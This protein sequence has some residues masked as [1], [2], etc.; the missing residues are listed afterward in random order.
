MDTDSPAP[1]GPADA[2]E[3]WT[4]RRRMAAAERARLLQARQDAE[5]ERAS[6]TISLF[7]QVAHAEG[8]TPQ[9]LRVQ[10]YSGGS[11]RTGLSGW[12]LRADR[13]VGIDTAGGFYVLSARLSWRERLLGAQPAPEPAP[14]TIGEGGRDGDIVPLR[15]ALDRLLP[16]WEERS[17]EPLP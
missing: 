5:H 12:Y 2:V 4:V 13:T 11:A 3:D 7:L 6:R 15:F 10:G 17:P 14:M 16:G 8:L 1:P 9:P